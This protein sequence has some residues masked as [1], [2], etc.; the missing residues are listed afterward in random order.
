VPTTALLVSLLGLVTLGVAGGSPRGW[1]LDAT[2]G[3]RPPKV[4]TAGRHYVFPLRVSKNHRNLVDRRGAP[5]MIIGDSPQALIGN[6]SAKAAAAYIANRKAAGFDALWVN[7]LCATYTGC[8]SDG[9]TFDGIAPFRRAGDLSTPNPAYFNRAAAML[10]LAQRAGMVVFLDPIE[11]GGWLDVLRS[12]GV[13]RDSAYGRF[14]GGRFQS[15]RNIVWLSGNDFQTWKDPDDDALVRAVATGI[16]SADP[17]ALQTVELD[18]LRSASRDDPRWRRIIKLDAAYTYFATYAEVLHEFQR[19]PP[20]P[21]F[22]LEAGYEFEQNQSSISYGSPETLRR[23][24]YWTALSGA[25]GQFYGNHFTWQFADGWQR[26]LDTTGSAQLG[27][28][29]NLLARRRWFRLVPDLGHRIVT[30]GYGTFAPNRNVSS[31]DYV[32]TAA[33]PD[34]RL[35][36]SYLPEGGTIGIDTRRMA[37]RVNARWYDPTSGR[38]TAVQGSPFAGRR[39]LDLTAPGRNHEGGRDWVLVLTA[40]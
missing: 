8:R 27:Y 20:M 33:T 21:V 11:T 37:G 22:L 18:Y 7:L 17:T 32:T 23:Q 1:E 4:L 34:G 29:V 3:V 14:V 6:L 30:K 10:R 12:N 28:L 13:A 39:S 36:I 35:A 9:S 26:N 16:H 31:S 40:P 15:F 38:Y 5:F 25:T 24:E 19:R 2:N